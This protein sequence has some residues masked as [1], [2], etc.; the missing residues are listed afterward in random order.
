MPDVRLSVNGADYGGWEKIRIVRGMEQIAGTFELTVSER[1]PG[2]PE[3]RAIR[4]GDECRVS[5]DGE[6]VI[7]GYIDDF[8]PQY[9]AGSHS[10]TVAGRDRTGDLVDCSAVH[11]P[12]EWRGLDLLGLA[13]A[14]AQPFGVSVRADTDLGPAFGTFALQESETAFEAIERAAKMRAVLLM[15][16]GR[17]GLLL[18]RASSERIGTALELGV[19]ILGARGSFSQKDRFSEYIVKGQ[20]KGTDDDFEAPNAITEVTARK[21][22]EGVKRYRP[23]VILA[24]D[25]GDG[26]SFERRI[27]WE[28]NTRLGKSI[29][30]TV[31]VQGWKHAGGLWAPNRTV[32]ITDPWQGLDDDLIIAQVQLMLDDRGTVTDLELTHPAAFDLLPEAEHQ[33]ASKKQKGGHGK[34]EPEQWQ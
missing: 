25:L 13:Q 2:T 21:A 4:P 31:T 34:A 26:V 19:N 27:A 8:M 29:R 20:R 30:S 24:E 9:D 18:T 10:V 22:D 16:D 32:H 5:V 17:G 23:L 11:S 15:S 12:G 3:G 28:R 7:T 6:T 1:W 33:K 14:I